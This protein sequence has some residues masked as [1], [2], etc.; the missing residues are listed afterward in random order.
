MS[1]SPIFE[2]EHK[3]RVWLP[4]GVYP[5]E[6]TYG[7]QPWKGQWSWS[8]GSGWS[9]CVCVCVCWG[10]GKGEECVWGCYVVQ[11]GCMGVKWVC[12]WD[13]SREMTPPV[14]G[15][16]VKKEWERKGEDGEWKREEG[17]EK[18]GG[19]KRRGVWGV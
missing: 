18:V 14:L 10:L 8:E 16:C 4:F 12:A 5:E 2:L 19:T 7:G 1:T 6:E 3:L 17:E 9:V 11:P 13:R 15:A